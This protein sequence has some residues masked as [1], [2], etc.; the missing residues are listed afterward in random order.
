MQPKDERLA[1]WKVKRHEFQKSGMSRRSWC[2]RNG[3]KPST[4]DYWLAR[5][6]KSEKDH[7][8]VE[9]Q[10]TVAQT[11]PSCLV[12]KVGRFLIEIQDGSAVALLA[13]TVK[14]LE[15]L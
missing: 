14:A 5:I 9:I 6:R 13:E 2:E 4:L 15:S 12:V 8:L 11:N 10:P 3:I 7:G 1:I